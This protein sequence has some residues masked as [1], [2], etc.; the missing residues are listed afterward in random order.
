MAKRETER[1]KVK[2]KRET[3]MFQKISMADMK[4]KRERKRE[5]PRTFWNAKWRQ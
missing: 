4:L 3:K 1:G 5:R 2:G